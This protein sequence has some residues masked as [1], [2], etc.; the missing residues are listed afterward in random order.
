M[1]GSDGDDYI[2]GGNDDDYIDGGD[3]DDHIYGGNGVNNIYGGDT[4]IFGIGY[5]IDTINASLARI[6]V[7]D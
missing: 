6:L 1:Y 2:Y 4:Y 5:D 7:T 3:G